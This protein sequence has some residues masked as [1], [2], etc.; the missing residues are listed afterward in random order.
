D[1]KVNNDPLR[2]TYLL[3][4][5]HSALIAWEVFMGQYEPSIHYH[6]K[7][8][9]YFVSDAYDND[10]DSWRIKVN[11]DCPKTVIPADPKRLANIVVNHLLEKV[12]SSNKG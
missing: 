8:D 7:D 9:C 10:D 6:H 3:K 4:E 12:R 5:G 2:G 1:I 11:C